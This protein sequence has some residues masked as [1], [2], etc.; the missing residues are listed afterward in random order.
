MKNFTKITAVF[1]ALIFAVSMASCSLTQQWSYKTEDTEL[2]VGVYIYS[3]YSAYN[4]AQTFAQ[5]SD[6]YDSESGKYDGSDSFLKIEITDD[7]GVTATADQWIIDK[8]DET[9]KNILA[10]YHAFNSLGATIDQ[11]TLDGYESAAKEYW[12]YG[13]YYAYYGEQ[14]KNPYSEVF[15]PLGVSYESFYIATYYT[16]AMQEAIFNSLYEASGTQAVSDE[17]LT[18]YFTSNYTSYSYFSADLYTTE[19][20]T[21]E[22]VDG[23][24]SDTDVTAALSDDEISKYKKSFE[25]YVDKIESGKSIDDVVSDYMSEYKVENDP[26]TSS[27]EIMDDSSIGDELKN[28]INALSEGKASYKIIG[29]DDSQVIYFFYKEPIKNQIKNYIESDTNRSTVLQN[30]KGE[31]LKAYIDDIAQNLDVTVSNTIKSYKP[32]MF[33]K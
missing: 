8:A 4:Q 6:L 18:D 25:K 17:E 31:D 1:L 30:M 21:V 16:A 3:L 26:S 5:E 28:E 12:D 27:V 10:T 33:E 14:Y 15:E 2:P 24:T 22:N 13:P 29:E 11:K 20:Q 32:K 9:V 19:T 23:T 7:D